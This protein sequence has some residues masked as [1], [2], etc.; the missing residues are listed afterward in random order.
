[1]FANSRPSILKIKR[2]VIIFGTGG[3]AV[4]AASLAEQCGYYVSCFVSFQKTIG[5]VNGRQ[6]L[7]IESFPSKSKISVVIA[8]GDNFLRESIAGELV[9]LAKCKSLEIAFPNLIH[10]SCHIGSHAQL[11]QG[12]Q[13]F[14]GANLGAYSRIE[15]F[16]VIN[17]LSS[18]DHESSM[19]SFAS[20]APAA[21]TGG[22]VKIG[23]RAAL[24]IN[25]TVSNGIAIGNDA[26][27]A[28]NS[29]VKENV[30]DNCLVAGSP[31]QFIRY[32]RA[33]DSYL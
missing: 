3:H 31:A 25:S 9:M 17:H 18:L 12:N 16:V 4:S 26:I 19:E 30:M 15:D 32:H 20:L 13:L 28:A 10:P 7:P 23:R 14:P 2:K 21:V 8:V 6:I 27:I 1:M 11:G 24:L 33:G 29:F 5:E 22:R